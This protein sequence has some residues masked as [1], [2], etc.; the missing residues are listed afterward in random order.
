MPGFI[1][2]LSILFLDLST[3]FIMHPRG[4]LCSKFSFSIHCLANHAS[5]SQKFKNAHFQ[6]FVSDNRSESTL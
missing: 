5:E 1:H 2:I 3:S 6:R 4:R